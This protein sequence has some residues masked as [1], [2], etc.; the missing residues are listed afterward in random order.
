MSAIT[1]GINAVREAI[2]NP[3]KIQKVLI[4]NGIKNP[5]AQKLKEEV[6]RSGVSFSFVPEQKL[7]KHTK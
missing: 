5:A 3:Y 7:Y 4:E 6:M 2:Q 1:F